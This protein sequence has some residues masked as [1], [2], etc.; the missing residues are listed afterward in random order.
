MASKKSTSRKSDDTNCSLSKAYVLKRATESSSIVWSQEEENT[1]TEHERL[2][3]QEEE[4]EEQHTKGMGFG[5]ES[6]DGIHFLAD[7]V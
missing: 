3:E 6:F 7:G 4:E 2:R 5:T 1:R